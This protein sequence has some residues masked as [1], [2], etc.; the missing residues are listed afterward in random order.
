MSDAGAAAQ[1]VDHVAIAVADA[2]AAARTFASLLGYAVT[3]DEVVRA[4][5]VRLVYLSGATD[6]DVTQL[7]LVQPLGPGP[8]AEFLA[9]HGEGLHH[10]CFRTADIAH[11]LRSAGESGTDGVFTG[12]RGRPCAFL[13]VTPHGVR[14][15]LTEVADVTAVTARKSPA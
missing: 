11:S 9:S 7:Q 13:T 5:G 1:A 12:G 14:V 6:A 3:G 15:E 4:A 2:D 10:V 8:V